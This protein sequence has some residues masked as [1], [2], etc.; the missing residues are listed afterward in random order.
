MKKV[1]I[2]IL[3][4]GCLCGCTINKVED[5]F[6]STEVSGI[7]MMIQDNSLTRESLKLV[8]KDMNGKGFYVYGKSFR[9]DKK[10]NDTWVGVEKL[11]NN[12]GFDL[13]AYYVNSDNLLE[14][15][16]NWECMYGSLDDGEYRLV[17]DVVLESD[18]PMTEEDKRYISISFVID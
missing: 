8:I 15:E 16:Q 9:I 7:S 5:K 18:I 12:C 13:I 17:K 1:F 14:M 10:E 4:I 6:V 2:F 3:I 11:N